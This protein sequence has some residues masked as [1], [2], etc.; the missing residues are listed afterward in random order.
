[1][2]THKDLR[3]WNEAIEFV[4]QIYKMTDGF[5]KSEMYGLTSQLRRASVS[6]PSNIAEGSARRGVKERTQFYAI[7]LASNSEIETQLIISKNLKFISQEEFKEM[8]SLN[9]KVGKQLVKL[10]QYISP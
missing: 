7:A 1:M 4:T 10:I 8:E 2:K 9:A 3:V 5:P 6:V